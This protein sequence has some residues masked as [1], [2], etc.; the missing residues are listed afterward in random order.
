MKRLV[1]ECLR[2][3]PGVGIQI[4]PNLSD[5]CP[6]LVPERMI[7]S[8]LDGIGVEQMREIQ[9]CMVG[10]KMKCNNRCLVVRT[11]C[12]FKY[13]RLSHDAYTVMVEVFLFFFF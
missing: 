12:G 13:V 2:L 8:S 4:P 5:G 7:P 6:A 9:T 1:R 3:I 10:S 11:L